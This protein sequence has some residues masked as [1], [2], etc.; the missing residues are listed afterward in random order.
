MPVAVDK[1][2]VNDVAAGARRSAQRADLSLTVAI[3]RLLGVHT[4]YFTDEKLAAQIGEQDACS[5]SA[6]ILG[7]RVG[8]S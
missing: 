4:G 5:C 1:P 3:A 8:G 2:S 6:T 7:C